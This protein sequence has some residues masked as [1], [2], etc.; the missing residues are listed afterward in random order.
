MTDGTFSTYFN[1]QRAGSLTLRGRKRTKLVATIGPA[2][3]D[4][5]VLREMYHLGMNVARL[6]MSHGAHA[7]HARRLEQVRRLSHE[8]ERPIAVLADLQ[9][10]KIRL[11]RFAGKNLQ[12]KEGDEITITTAEC[13][14]GTLERVGTT[15][16]DLHLD[17][18][19]GS[20]LLI[21]D[22]KLRFTVLSI[23]G[24]DVRCR[25]EVGGAIS[26]NKGINLPNVD[27]SAPTLSDKDKADLAWAIEHEV[28]FIALSF[29]RSAL[30]VRNVRRRIAECGRRI[31]IVAKIERPEAVN[32]IEN[33]L[34]ESDAIMVA[35]GDLG[36][37]ID[38]ERVPVVQKHL[39]ARANAH[40]KLVITATQMLDSM[41]GS[42]IPTRAE[43]TDVANAIFDGTDAVM[44]SGE[45]A[46]G[47]YP[48]EAVEEMLKIA[49]EAEE[50][51]YIRDPEVDY[52]RLDSDRLAIA[53]TGAAEYLAS[54]IDAAGVMIFSH[55]TE[56]GE[57]LA[58]RRVKRT[59]TICYD[60]AAWRRQSILWGSVPLRVDFTDDPHDL[61]EAGIAEAL[62]QGALKPGDQV[63]VMMGFAGDNANSLRVVQV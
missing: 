53:L 34:E 26:S 15:Y 40:G 60:D 12:I 9:G 47:G 21:D 6:N 23:D 22:G 17:V 29:V 27:V 58:K 3:E 36:I 30:D 51:P 42:P 32:D 2:C 39:I 13:E 33:I 41:I 38:T 48:C 45:T 55:G 54:T 57:L 31:G 56:K 8:L 52:T 14:E 28:D 35:R 10:P 43:T 25:V 50:S 16:T 24:Q 5:D 44:L 7:D 4:E 18:K 19:P 63:V 59:I 46:V 1:R 61:L 62:R 37:E 20:T 11:G 49:I